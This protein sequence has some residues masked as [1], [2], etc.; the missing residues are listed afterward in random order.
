MT[1]N[2]LLCARRHWKTHTGAKPYKCTVC[3]RTFS[4]RDSCTRYTRRNEG[5]NI[6]IVNIC[7]FHRHI[8]TVHRDVV[9]LTKDNINTL[10]DVTDPDFE[11]N[12]VMTVQYTD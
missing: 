9:D 4:L 10:V 7:Y 5:V 2:Y 6:F 11:P 8:R 1:P 3:T 12:N